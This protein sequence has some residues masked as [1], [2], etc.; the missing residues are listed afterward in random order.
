MFESGMGS[1]IEDARLKASETLARLY[2]EHGLSM[3]D[4]V[5]ATYSEDLIRRE[6][7][8]FIFCD[9]PESDEERAAR[10][11]LVSKIVSEVHSVK[12]ALRAYDGHARDEKPVLA[13][14]LIPR[15]A[16]VYLWVI[17]GR[18]LKERSR[19]S[20]VALLAPKPN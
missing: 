4:K 5:V 17:E 7:S 13:D 11:G 20:A 3:L 14:W 10:E 16:E 8:P 12:A 2:Q 18:N 9:R 19:R 1:C 6:F 15:L